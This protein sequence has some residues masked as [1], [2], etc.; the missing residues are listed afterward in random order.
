LEREADGL[1]LETMG[2]KARLC[3]LLLALLPLG[4]MA[5]AEGGLA[6][7]FR[8]AGVFPVTEDMMHFR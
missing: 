6:E 1:G 2:R 3:P 5:K 8:V 4:P 7:L